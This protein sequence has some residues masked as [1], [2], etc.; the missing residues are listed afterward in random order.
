MGR[1]LVCLPLCLLVQPDGQPPARLPERAALATVVD[2]GG[3]LPEEAAMVQLAQTD[4]IAF[5][6]WS[7]IRYDRE[8]TSGYRT[9][10]IK[11]ERIAG[12]L[13]P[14][15]D[16]TVDFRE[17]PFSVLFCYKTPVRAKRVLYVKPDNDKGKLVAQLAGAASLLISIVE[18]DP[19]GPDARASSRY[20]IYD[21]GIK[22]GSQRTLAAWEAAKKEGTLRLEFLG[23]K[24]I[25]ELGDRPCWVLK[26]TRYR[27]PEEDGI[28][29]ATF[30]FDKETWMQTGSILKDKDG[31]LIGDYWFRAVELNPKFDDDTFTRKSLEKK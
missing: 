30:Y 27:P 24:K 17:K 10:F 7:L 13:N 21:F 25:K 9:N 3:K 16:I 8:V 4:P 6:R 15:E 5:I 31:K 28:A 1:L 18:R 12:K 11:Q 22:V 23:E 20:A 2:P 14:S 19:D 29:E 26:R